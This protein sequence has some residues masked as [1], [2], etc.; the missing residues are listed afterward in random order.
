[1]NFNMNVNM[2]YGSYGNY[3]SYGSG[4]MQQMQQMQMMQMMQ[5]NTIFIV[6]GVIPSFVF[7]I[8]KTIPVQRFRR[9]LSEL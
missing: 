7:F 9:A 5:L 6:K 8:T 4:M 3:G 1:M 2:G